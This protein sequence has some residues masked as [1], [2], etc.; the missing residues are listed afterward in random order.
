MEQTGFEIKD[1]IKFAACE[2][3]VKRYAGKSALK[4]SFD[5]SEFMA[6]IIDTTRGEECAAFLAHFASASLVAQKH[7]EQI[8]LSEIVD[9]VRKGIR[10]HN[11]SASGQREIYSKPNICGPEV[12]RIKFEILKA[13]KIEKGYRHEID[14]NNNEPAPEL[15]KTE[16]VIADVLSRQFPAL[17][18]DRAEGLIRPKNNTPTKK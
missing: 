1:K 3:I 11:Y 8:K 6:Y 17:V 5:V 18:Q 12:S 10:N 14:Y 7:G 15:S 2:E 4:N 9:V 16:T 13:A